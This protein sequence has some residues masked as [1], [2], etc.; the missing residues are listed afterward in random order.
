M[1]PFF[2]PLIIIY[3]T[4]ICEISQFAELSMLSS[5]GPA[6]SRIVIHTSSRWIFAST[7]QM[8]HLGGKEFLL[9]V[10]NERPYHFPN[11]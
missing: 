7:R 10:T 9:I 1:L 4:L 6:A 2:R 5:I 8:L 11:K 3:C